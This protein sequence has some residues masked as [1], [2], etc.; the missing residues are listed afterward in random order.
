[1]V[2]STSFNTD[3]AFNVD[4]KHKCQK[5]TATGPASIGTLICYNDI[6]F[7]TPTFLFTITDPNL[8]TITY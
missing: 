3:Y 1:M 2:G 6:S 8:C 5:P 4:L 7:T